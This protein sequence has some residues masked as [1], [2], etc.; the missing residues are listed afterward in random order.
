MTISTCLRGMTKT[1][2][3]CVSG[4]FMSYYAQSWVSVVI[5]KA[6]DTQYM[7]GRH[8]RKLGIFAF[9]AV[10]VSYCPLFGFLGRFTR[11][12]TIYTCLRGMAK[13]SSFL[14]FRSV[15]VSYCP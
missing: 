4:H 14:R 15:F 12:M 8:D 9:M 3:F 13:K 2:H 1:Q 5:Y 11:N 6:H 7:F 10:F